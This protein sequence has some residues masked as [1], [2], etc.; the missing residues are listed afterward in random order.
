MILES[1]FIS[2][3]V[4]AVVNI[5]INVLCDYLNMLNISEEAKKA[6]NL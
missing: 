3:I 4:S 6:F 1:I 5:T 2:V